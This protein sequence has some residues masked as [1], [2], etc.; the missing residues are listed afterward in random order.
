MKFSQDFIN[1]IILGDCFET[2]KKIPDG[3][4]DLV[5]TSPPYNLKNS[6]GNGMKDGR[7][8]KWANA[9]LVNGYHNYDDC[10]PHDKYVKWQRACLEEMMRV[11]NDHGAIF[12][13]HKWRVQD[14]LLQD[15]QDIVSGFPV[16]QIIIWRRKGGINFNAGYFLPTYEV[17]YLITK[18]NF[19]LA[20]KA[21]AY[22]D[23]WEF[24]QEMNNPHPA[25]FPVD[26]IE[27]IISSTNADVILDP[28][29]GSGTTAVVAKKL[30][31]KYIGIE[32]SPEYCKMAENRIAGNGMQRESKELEP[33]MDLFKQLQKV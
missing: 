30:G 18:K 12:Y 31:R 29:M 19:K 25:A 1:K 20:P 23:I 15:R 33:Q 6:T 2:M 13:N 28:F 10:M 9:A 17:I 27:R 14:G 26:L 7:G 8:G 4:V 21:N 24:T 5:V 22:G 3:S 32:I 11:I 16:R